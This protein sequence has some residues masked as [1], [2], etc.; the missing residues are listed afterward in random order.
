[1]H[2]SV[3][4]HGGCILNCQDKGLAPLSALLGVEQL[5]T[6]DSLMGVISSEDSWLNLAYQPHTP[7]HNTRVPGRVFALHS[8]SGVRSS[9]CNASG[10]VFRDS[11]CGQQASSAAAEFCFPLRGGLASS[12]CCNAADFLALESLSSAFAVESLWAPRHQ[13]PWSLAVLCTLDQRQMRSH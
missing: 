3:Y 8:I 4:F 7:L 11:W 2:G 9:P 6:L 1:M 5:P 12:S 10:R 13:L